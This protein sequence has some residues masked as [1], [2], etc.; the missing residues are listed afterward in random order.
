MQKYKSIST[1]KQVT[2]IQSAMTIRSLIKWSLNTSQIHL[3]LKNDIFVFIFFAHTDSFTIYSFP[4][5]RVVKKK[6]R[7]AHIYIVEKTKRLRDSQCSKYYK[8]PPPLKLQ[9]I[10]YAHRL[11][12]KEEKKLYCDNI[13]LKLDMSSHWKEQTQKI[14]TTMALPLNH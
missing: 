4:F 7:A 2:D 13:P 9:H 6:S 5:A 14:E 11:L 1:Y 8:T 3:K 12:D 10:S